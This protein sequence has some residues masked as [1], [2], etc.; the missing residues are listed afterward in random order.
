N[1]RGMSAEDGGA[2][3]SGVVMQTPNAAERGLWCPLTWVLLLRAPAVR[4]CASVERSSVCVP[5]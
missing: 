4:G 5:G 2:G 3:G 1:A